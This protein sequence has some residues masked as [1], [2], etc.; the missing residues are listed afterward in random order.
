MKQLNINGKLVELEKKRIKNMYLRILAPDGRIH[1]SAPYGMEEER[2]RSFVLSKLDWI[3]QK[4]IKMEQRNIAK[5]VDYVTGDQVSV[6]GNK[7]YL[8]V[9]DNKKQNVVELSDGNI[10][11]YVKKNSTN[12]QRARIIDLWYRSLLQQTALPL[13]S[14]WEKIIGVKSSG[15]IIRDMKTR[16]GTCNVR[17][18]RICLNLQLAKKPPRCL[19]YVIVHELVHLLEGSHN[20]IFKGYMDRYLPDW[21]SV[22]KELNKN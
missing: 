18:G 6:W 1:I 7:L 9:K 22:R 15:L 2:I 19:E 20:S 12:L 16:W 17:T 8:T 13:I 14:Q 3:E 4:Q 10:I 11:L 5:K 21:R